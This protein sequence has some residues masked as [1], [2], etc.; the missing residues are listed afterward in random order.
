MLTIKICL[1]TGTYVGNDSMYKREIRVSGPGR[2]L[3]VQV[4]NGRLPLKNVQRFF[5]SC[6]GC[7]YLDEEDETVV[8]QD[9]DAN[10]LVPPDVDNLTIS[11]SG[12][13]L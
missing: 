4:I 11:Y 6:C 8:M 9:S 13:A 7:T 1:G 2:S 5:P 3:K 12:N 10:L